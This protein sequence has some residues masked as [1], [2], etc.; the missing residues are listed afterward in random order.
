MSAAAAGPAEGAPS[1]PG[2]VTVDTLLSGRVALRQPATGYRVALDPVLLAAAARVA[3]G[4]SVADFGCGVGA[5]FLCVA[6]RVPDVTVTGIET[7]D[8]L[9]ALA[10]ENARANNLVAEM[11]WGRVEEET[12]DPVD[13]VLMNPP[14]HD[15]GTDASENADKDLAHRGRDRLIED[16]IAI[17][18]RSL[19]PRGRLSL[20]YRADRLSRVLAALHP[21][22][23]AVEILPLWPK[24][25][26]AAKRVIVRARRDVA[27]PGALLPGLVLHEVGG[28]LTPAAR[29]IVE[30]PTVLAQ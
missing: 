5:A 21:R 19:R 6:A 8:R 28:G 22:F 9:A 11:I 17:A 23:Q 7:V 24:A 2:A 30:A 18:H 10:Q 1:D 29:A 12:I 25:G 26:A 27:S 4:D 15:A 13:H 16:W 14:F 20:I 3:P